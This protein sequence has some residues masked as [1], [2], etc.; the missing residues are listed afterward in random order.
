V[1][2]GIKKA[3]GGKTCGLYELFAFVYFRLI[4]YKLSPGTQA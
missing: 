3:A 4:Q 1:V 2:Q